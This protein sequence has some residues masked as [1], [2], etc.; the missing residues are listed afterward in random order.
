MRCADAFL[1]VVPN[2]WWC[3]TLQVQL[4]PR[5][6]CKELCK[7]QEQEKATTT[8]TTRWCWQLWRETEHAPS[9]SWPLSKT[10]LCKCQTC[11][12][13]QTTTENKREMKYKTID[14]GEASFKTSFLFHFSR[15]SRVLAF[16]GGGPV[17]PPR[18]KPKRRAISLSTEGA[19]AG[20]AAGDAAADANNC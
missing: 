19:G 8:T 3:H 6:R 9:L 11:T 7:L 17:S 16:G 20:A 14:I 15:S 18:L 10:P 5:N 2:R 1:R 13:Y 12:N 4:C